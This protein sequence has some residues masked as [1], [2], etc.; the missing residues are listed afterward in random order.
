MLHLYPGKFAN[1][2]LEAT[3]LCSRYASLS[4]Y[5][6]T[7]GFIL[8]YLERLVVLSSRQ[9]ST[10]PTSECLLSI[11]APWKISGIVDV[12]TTC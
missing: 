7:Q 9:C 2:I 5:S 1:E 12:Y 10:N 3:Q 4:C 6:L 8:G 11:Y